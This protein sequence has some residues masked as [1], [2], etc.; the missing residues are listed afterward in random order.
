MLE[1]RPIY[2]KS[3]I[4]AAVF[5][6]DAKSPYS[7]N[8]C[9]GFV[10]NMSKKWQRNLHSLFTMKDLSRFLL[11]SHKKLRLHPSVKSP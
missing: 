6:V 10:L 3:D 9:V 8:R 4:F 5:A 2:F 11:T 1:K 7:F